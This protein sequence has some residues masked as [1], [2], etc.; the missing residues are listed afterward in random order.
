MGAHL[1]VLGQDP[2]RVAGK[3]RH[4]V[5]DQL[6]WALGIADDVARRLVETLPG[7]V[8]EQVAV[9]AVGQVEDD[10][11]AGVLEAGG[12]GAERVFEDVLAVRVVAEVVALPV[13]AV[14]GGVAFEDPVVAGDAGAVEAGANRVV[15]AQVGFDVHLEQPLQRACR[16]R[17][18]EEV[19]V[20]RRP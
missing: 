11:A 10:L 19:V 17:Q 16:R 1:I 5:L 20:E 6:V 2:L 12:A 9:Q 13:G 15:V 3:T 7:A 14:G 4:T 8:H 18:V